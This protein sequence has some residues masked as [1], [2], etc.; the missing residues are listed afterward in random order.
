[1]QTLPDIKHIS[2]INTNVTDRQTDSCE[3][4]Q[5]RVG[6][7]QA[8]RSRPTDSKQAAVVCLRLVCTSTCCRY[9]HAPCTA[10]HSCSNYAGRTGKILPCSQMAF[11]TSYRSRVFQL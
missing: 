8:N 4:Q 6:V 5:F 7:L 1:M 3:W 2:D 9:Q 11:I 10:L